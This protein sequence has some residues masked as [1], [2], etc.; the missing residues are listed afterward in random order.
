MS[1]KKKLVW[2]CFI[3]FAAGSA[4]PAVAQSARN[5]AVLS[6]IGDSL[7]IVTAAPVT[8]SNRDRN[9]HDQVRL[10]D[11][12]ID[13]TAL[14]S[15]EESLLKHVPDAK[16]TL[17]RVTD[18]RVFELQDR[19]LASEGDGSELFKDV[20]GI[21][22]TAGASHLILIAKYKS[23]AY[24]RVGN[25]HT[26]HGKLTGLGFYIDRNKKLTRSDTGE[27]G[28]GFLAP[29]CYIKVTMVD[30]Q[31][32]AIIRSETTSYG[33]TLSAARAKDSLNPWDVLSGD[34][35]SAAIERMVRAET[36]RLVSQVLAN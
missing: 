12:A 24:L 19:V 29:F 32:G 1:Y 35:K 16:V 4:Q 25:G 18:P 36:G 28:R 13:N 30:A 22:Q 17:L 10:N 15:A 2:I 33:T 6:L 21:A 14:K 20:L 7:D 11:A 31:S 23:E 27:S 5:F 34:E 26:G 3:A 9:Q 8:G